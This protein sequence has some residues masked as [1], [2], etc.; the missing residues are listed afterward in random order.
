[1]MIT[2]P[3]CSNDFPL[4][5]G[6]CNACT[7]RGS[8]KPE[9]FKMKVNEAA[10]ETSVAL[11]R[12][13]PN[14]SSASKLKRNKLSFFSAPVAIIGLSVA[15]VTAVFLFNAWKD[16]QSS[17]HSAELGSAAGRWLVVGDKFYDP[18]GSAENIDAVCER[19]FQIDSSRVRDK[20]KYIV[21]CKIAFF[22][23]QTNNK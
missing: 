16:S 1:M 14:A 4:D 15:V 17:D 10:D 21:A 20:Q 9:Q 3:K 18:V 6:Y 7:D 22:S 12:E 13:V 23:A 5:Y 11:Y 8:I 2:C 19:N